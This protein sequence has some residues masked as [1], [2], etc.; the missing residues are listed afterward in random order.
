MY[1]LKL[2]S[3][4]ACFSYT[5]NTSNT[6]IHY[7]I[8]LLSSDYMLCIISPDETLKSSVTEH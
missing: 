8:N 4:L 2:F 5:K 7:S 1:N 3:A 6:L